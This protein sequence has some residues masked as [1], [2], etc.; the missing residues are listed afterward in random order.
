MPGLRWLEGAELTAAEP[1]LRALAGLHSPETAIVDFAAVAEAYAADL[2]ADGGEVRTAPPVSAVRREGGH[3][4]VAL[5][6][7]ASEAADRVVVCAGLG[8]D[9]LARASGEP[10]RAPHRPVSPGEYWQ[11]VP[12]RTGLVRGL[13]YPVPDPAL[14]FLGGFHFTPRIGGEV[15]L[16]PNAALS[17]SRERYDR[18]LAVNGRESVRRLN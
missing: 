7:G 11:L 17:L 14:P 6:G 1:R 12:G 2:I 4:T 18:R 5:A 9:R 16:G 15:W 8:A 10:R 3:L 13:I